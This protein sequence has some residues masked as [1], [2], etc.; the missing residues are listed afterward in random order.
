M[1]EKKRS[2]KTIDIVSYVLKV[3]ENCVTCVFVVISGHQ[4][5]L[6]VCKLA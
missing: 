3:N 1:K 4:S 2:S 6:K 5:H